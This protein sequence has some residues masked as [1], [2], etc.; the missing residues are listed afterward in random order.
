M[1]EVIHYEVAKK[2]K[3]VG[4]VDVRIPITKPAVLI[5]R[6]ITHVQSGNR[7]WCNLPSFFIDGESGQSGYQKFFQFEEESHNTALL[8]PLAKKVKEYCEKHGIH[9]S[10][11]S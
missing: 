2:G 4:Y 9:L 3:T 10:K 8:N 11:E 7:R 5:L 6:K 1:A